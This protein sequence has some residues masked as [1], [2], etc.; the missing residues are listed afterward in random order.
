MSTPSLMMRQVFA[1]QF[2]VLCVKL[3][4][5][6]NIIT[7]CTTHHALLCPIY[8]TKIGVVQLSE[9]SCFKSMALA[10]RFGYPASLRI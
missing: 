8:R 9:A 1:L 4:N 7:V 3:S 6:I 10:S 2:A 5:V